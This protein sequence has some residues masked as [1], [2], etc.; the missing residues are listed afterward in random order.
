MGSGLRELV[1]AH[2]AG[3]LTGFDL[4]RSNL[5]L[6]PRTGGRALIYGGRAHMLVDSQNRPMVR[7][8]LDGSVPMS[9]VRSDLR[10]LGVVVT[11]ADP[12]WRGRWR[13]IC[14]SIKPKR[15]RPCR[16]FFRCISCTRRASTSAR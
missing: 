14:R 10:T 2:R 12:N 5:A 4:R 9:K 15:L 8:V 7:I 16:E 1:E 3:Q 11:A 13:P 6:N